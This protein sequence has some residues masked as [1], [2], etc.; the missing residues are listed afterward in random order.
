MRLRPKLLGDI[1]RLDL[2]TVPPCHFIAS[3]VQLAVMTAAKW[4]CELI[5]H[6]EAERSGL[7]KAKMMRIAGL[8]A[9]GGGPGVRL[10]KRSRSERSK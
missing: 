7:C 1:E 4:D 3:L 6:F 9:A 10:R 8:S 5:T 2:E